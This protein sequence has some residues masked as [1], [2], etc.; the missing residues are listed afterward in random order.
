MIAMILFEPRDFQSQFMTEAIKV[1]FLHERKV[2]YS[3][4]TA[5]QIPIIQLYSSTSKK[6][7]ALP[8]ILPKFIEVG[9]LPKI[10]FSFNVKYYLEEH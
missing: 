3:E 1:R 5:L 2:T 4:V 7:P 10:D 8:V 6:I 9:K